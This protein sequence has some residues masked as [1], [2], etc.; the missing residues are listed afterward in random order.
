MTTTITGLL[1]CTLKQ[2]EHTDYITVK[3]GTDG[4]DADHYD[5]H[6]VPTH[7]EIPK[8]LFNEWSGDGMYALELYNKTKHDTDLYMTEGLLRVLI[9]DP[10]QSVLIGQYDKCTYLRSG[11]H[12]HT[13]V[14]TYRS[15]EQLG[16]YL[17]AG[18]QVYVRAK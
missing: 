14:F 9:Y 10:A 3:P 6:A 16:R 8:D 13:P 15:P 2:S 11:K 5:Y 18:C 12:R 17:S 4:T 7:S 1:I